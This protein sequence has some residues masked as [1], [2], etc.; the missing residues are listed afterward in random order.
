M[1]QP[2]GSKQSSMHASDWNIGS[3]IGSGPS[4]QIVLASLDY[5][6]VG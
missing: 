2:E 4:K 5:A 6:S 1:T 3:S